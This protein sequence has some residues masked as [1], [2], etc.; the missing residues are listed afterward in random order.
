MR[1][2]QTKDSHRDF[3]VLEKGEE[4]TRYTNAA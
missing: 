3:V 4:N 1:T 2:A